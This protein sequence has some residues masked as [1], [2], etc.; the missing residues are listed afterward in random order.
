MEDLED[1]SDL[2]LDVSGYLS[3]TATATATATSAAAAGREEQ[4]NKKTTSASASP[5]NAFDLVVDLVTPELKTRT[6]RKTGGKEN[7][8][9]DVSAG[10]KEEEEEVRRELVIENTKLSQHSQHNNNTC[11]TIDLCSSSEEEE[12]R[13]VWNENDESEVPP[14][15]LM[16]QWKPPRP[17]RSSSSAAPL[18]E[19]DMNEIE[20]RRPNTH[21]GNAE[22]EH[23]KASSRFREVAGDTRLIHHKTAATSAFV[24]ALPPEQDMVTMSQVSASGVG[25]QAAAEKQA[26]RAAIKRKRGDFALQEMTVL[27]SSQAV[28]HP[29][30][31]GLKVCEAVLKQGMKY[32]V[33]SDLPVRRV[34]SVFW[35]ACCSQSEGNDGMI[36]S[37][38][39]LLEAPEFINY[40]N[41]GD[42]AFWDLLH[43]VSEACV[44]YK[45]FCILIGWERELRL[46]EKRDRCFSPVKYEEKIAELVIITRGLQI[47]K[48]CDVR[49]AADLLSLLSVELA[50]LPYKSRTESSVA[51]FSKKV[52]TIFRGAQRSDENKAWI[53]MIHQLPHIG[54]KL[55]ES[56]AD[57]FGNFSTFMKQ[58]TSDAL[59]VSEKK[60]L[61]QGLP[62]VGPGISQK[63]FDYFTTRDGKLQIK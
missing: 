45:I 13:N 33:K 52:K 40:V 46:R 41:R 58:Y 15:P 22:G 7:F 18:S 63:F 36:P 21:R 27:V 26:K 60:S 61:L 20:A 9:D 43:S 37:V 49:G 39:I 4:G 54:I 31:V 50:K 32:E 12:Q 57:S 51:D 44:G 19:V 25:A 3:A 5:S 48:V 6:S 24:S 35:K 38:A 62:K 55:A 23:D 42:E 1:D 47:H 14:P 30:L 29:T 28:E 16:K 56:I 10:R 17:S 53:K 8:E 2:L 59:N 34:P 11:L